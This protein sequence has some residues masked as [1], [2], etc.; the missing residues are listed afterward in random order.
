M[1]LFK[2]L[3][4]VAGI[5]APLASFIPGVGTAISAGLGAMSNADGSS[6]GVNYAQTEESNRAYQQARD[7]ALYGQGGYQDLYTNPDNFM[8][9]GPNP[10]GAIN[11]NEQNSIDQYANF[12]GNVFPGMFDSAMGAANTGLSGGGQL[13]NYASQ[14]GSILPTLTG[15]LGQPAQITNPGFDPSQYL[16]MTQGLGVDPTQGIQSMLSGNLDTNLFQGAIDSY[17]QPAM[18]KFNEQLMPSFLRADQAATGGQ[19][20]AG[21]LKAAQRT[22]EQIGEGL[23]AH[24]GGLLYNSSQNAA[25]RVGQG[26]GL[27]LNQQGMGLQGLGMAGDFA[28]MNSQFNLQSQLANQQG[29]QQWINSMLSG[30]GLGAGAAGD[31]ATNQARWG[32]L[33]PSL[34][35]FGQMGAEAYGQAGAQQ[36]ALTDPN[37]QY[38]FQQSMFN[39]AQ[40]FD[41]ASQWMN[42]LNGSAQQQMPGGVAPSGGGLGQSLL[43]GISAFMGNYPQGGTGTSGTS[44]TTLFSQMPN[45]NDPNYV[46][47]KAQGSLIEDMWKNPSYL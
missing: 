47:G 6:T 19:S 33:L 26:A 10:F 18:E 16:S 21:A 38:A 5:A 44:G 12:A 36:R 2:K 7:A 22:Q 40:P 9:Y 24:I 34:G 1:G 8:Q 14:L 28:N 17:L 3:K 32:S 37:L 13:G 35:Q 31:V 27:A 25:N 15:A 46:T 45:Y 20:S 11:Q 39:Q 23:G 29:Q 30:A 41:M 42:M 43:G 4:K